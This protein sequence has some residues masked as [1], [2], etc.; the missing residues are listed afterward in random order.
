MVLALDPVGHDQYAIII[1]GDNFL[2]AIQTKHCA[3]LFDDFETDIK[4]F[5]CERLIGGD[6]IGVGDLDYFLFGG[7]GIAKILTYKISIDDTAMAEKPHHD[8]M[9]HLG[10][11][12]FPV[13]A[14]LDEKGVLWRPGITEATVIAHAFTGGVSLITDHIFRYRHGARKLAAFFMWPENIKGSQ[15][16]VMEWISSNRST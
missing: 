13:L 16:V 2:V 3:G 4:I 5:P 1:W 14:T 15:R 9:R 8:I 7:G 6:R 12:F 10:G 11:A